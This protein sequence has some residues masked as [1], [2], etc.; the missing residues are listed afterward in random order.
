LVITLRADFYAHCAGY[1]QLRQALADQQEYIGAMNDDE[2]QR[3]I[4][5]P[6]RRGRWELEPGLVDL[7]LHDV[8]H[9]PGALPLLS[10][11]LLETW[12]RRQGRMLTLSGYASSGGVRGAIAE[13]A[14]AVFADQ[15]T[16][17]QRTIARRIFLRLTE[18]GDET[19]TGD[20]RR[21]A[22]FTELIL[23]PEETD[24]TQTVLKALADARLIITTQD[25]AEVA[26]E[27]LIREWPTLRGWLEDNREGLRLHRHLTETAQ[28]W[29]NLNREPYVLYR[30]ARLAQAREWRS[31]HEDETNALEREFLAASIE[32]TEREAEEREAQR[33]RELEAAQTLAEAQRQRAEAERQRAEV[34]TQRAEEQ[35]RTSGQLRKRALFLAG[36]FTVALIM[37]LAA[38][39]FSA[40]AR[41]AAVTAQAN[42]R[43]AFS[44]ELAAASISNLDID[45]ERSVLLALEA[46]DTSYTIEAED[47]LHRAVQASRVQMVL[48]THPPGASTAVDFSPDGKHVVTSSRRDEFVKVWDL[49]TGEPLFTMDGHCA[50]YSPDGK[51]IAS[52]VADG[53]VKMWDALN[54]KEILIPN[55]ITAT[56]CVFFSPDGLYLVTGSNDGTLR[57][58]NAKT[59]QEQ[60]TFQG[61]T[62]FVPFAFFSPDGRRLLSV[63]DDG[64]ARLWN[65]RTGEELRLLSDDQVW[66]AAF[67]P[68]GKRI[69]TVGGINENNIHMWDAETG[70]QLFMMIG[71]TDSII[72][73][74]FNPDGSWLATSGADRKLKVWEA[75][76]GRELF[77]LTGHTGEVY[78]SDFSPDGSQLATS[79]TDGTVRIWDLSPSHESLTISAHGSSGQ[80]A[81]N[82]DGSRLATIND[83]EGIKLWDAHSGSELMSLP[84]TG[85]NIGDLLFSP[86]GTRIFRAADDSKVKIWDP[87]TGS[88]LAVI[89]GHTGPL[90]EIAMTRDGKYLATTS[91]DYKAKIW[92]VS[93]G[94]ISD[95]PLFTL[96]HSG[97]VFSAAFNRDGSKLATGVQDGTVIVWD[98]T[99]GREI[100]V[101]RGHADAVTE[102]VFSPDGTRI[103]TSSWDGTA[104]VW[105]VST[106]EALFTL[107]GHTGAVTSI[108]YSPDDKRIATVSLDGTAKLWDASTGE[109]YLTFF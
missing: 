19:A 85:S 17:E 55:Q 45:P 14:E 86:D 3:A 2:L 29:I 13:T 65:A 4:E 9:E 15:F 102:V 10:H 76:T 42:E 106:A 80:L 32:A 6:A 61:H 1:V 70:K 64:T 37:A 87:A 23:K 109:E 11:A 62:G 91:A 50:I 25:S 101:L 81:F 24:T 52:V 74:G 16:S 56:I 77:A 69:A 53:T 46:L 107:R 71:H 66:S 103:A 84:D 96:Q 90:Y 51:R 41:G 26:H 59:G 44:R 47:A 89:S 5:E 60:V 79:S 38:L 31:A 49:A 18:L 94:K 40:Q 28:E 95:T 73:V 21:R 75:A 33:Q 63:S 27:A 83:K 20:T 7:L 100:R 12:Q 82:M 92:D 8:G 58:W 72:G 57:I 43:L 104:K 67:S 105:N 22:T 88:E 68:D 78:A 30:G 93:S 98:T 39:F 54:G 99:N 48:Q 34:E 35:V 97:V 108:A 36:A